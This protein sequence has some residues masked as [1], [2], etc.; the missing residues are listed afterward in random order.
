MGKKSLVYYIS[1]CLVGFVFE[2]LKATFGKVKDVP[3]GDM[4]WTLRAGNVKS[5][6]LLL[7]V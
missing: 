7:L 2:A 1:L 4:D 5:I 3:R 6:L